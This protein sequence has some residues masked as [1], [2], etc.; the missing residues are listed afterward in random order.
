MAAN[1][2][3]T[4]AELQKQLNQIQA[5]TN[6]NDK[7]KESAAKRIA[8]AIKEQ[9]VETELLLKSTKDYEDTLKSINSSYGKNNKLAKEASKIIEHT[10]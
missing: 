1:E 7:E 3:K 9:R 2:K 10:K 8:Q 5:S 4:I 6:L